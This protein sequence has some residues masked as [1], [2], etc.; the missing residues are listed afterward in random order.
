MEEW[1]NKGEFYT[2][3]NGRQN[4]KRIRNVRP[5][6]DITNATFEEPIASN[7][8]PINA[9]L[10]MSNSDNKWVTVLTDRSSGKEPFFHREVKKVL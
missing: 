8:Y 4:L 2:D 10:S 3:A 6:Y 7:Y 1:D 5:D 9:W